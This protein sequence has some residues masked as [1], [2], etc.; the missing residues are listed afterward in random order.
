MSSLVFVVLVWGLVG[1]GGVSAVSAASDAGLDA[2]VDAGGQEDVSARSDARPDARAAARSDTGPT[3]DVGVVDAGDV[4]VERETRPDAARRDL[5]DATSADVGVDAGGDTDVS[6]EEGRASR[7]QKSDDAASG[8][9]ETDEQADSKESQ[10]SEETDDQQKDDARSKGGGPP[11]I[12]PDSLNEPETYRPFVLSLSVPHL[13]LGAI[14][15]GSGRYWP[16]LELTGEFQRAPRLSI[17]PVAGG[18]L[19]TTDSGTS[20]VILAGAQGRAY[21]TDTFNNGIYAAAEVLGTG[22]VGTGNAD[23]TVGVPFVYSGISPSLML[24]LKLNPGGGFMID[25]QAGIGARHLLADAFSTFNP[26]LDPSL[27]LTVN[28]NL[29][30]G[31]AAE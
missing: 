8:Q 17:A 11:T 6:A 26:N 31:F 30:W 7:D 3:A 24:G 23:P 25:T 20:G 10:G 15:S 4:G 18:M 27:D 22:A 19:V 29:G 21:I 28:F 13:L 1:A 5:S 12:S 9:A 16:M 2:P 14:S